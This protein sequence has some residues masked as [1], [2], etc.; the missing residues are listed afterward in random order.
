MNKL[1]VL[2]ERLA[3]SL[4]ADIVLS[5]DREEHIRV[6][7]RANEAAELVNDLKN[8]FSITARQEDQS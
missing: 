1:L 3:D 4:K 7:A 2:A 8:N 6:T 5:K